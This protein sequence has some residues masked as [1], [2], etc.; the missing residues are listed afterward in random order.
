METEHEVYKYLLIPRLVNKLNSEYR[1][2]DGE[3]LAANQQRQYDFGLP[4]KFIRWL[5]ATITCGVSSTPK[6]GHREQGGGSSFSPS[7][8]K[9]VVLG[10]S[11][12]AR[13][14]LA[15]FSKSTS[16]R[17]INNLFDQYLLLMF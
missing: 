8:A 9:Y 16:I 10:Y 3:S 6:M 12:G 5:A 1:S 14:L 4:I 7:E 13:P 2:Y 17:L 15:S 11:L